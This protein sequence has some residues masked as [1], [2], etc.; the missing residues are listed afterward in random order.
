MSAVEV[1]TDQRVRSYGPGTWEGRNC[2]RSGRWG[3]S[4]AWSV[5]VTPFVVLELLIWKPGGGFLN[6]LV[7]NGNRLQ[8][9]FYFPIW[10]QLSPCF[11]RGKSVFFPHFLFFHVFFLS[12]FLIFHIFPIIFPLF[13]T[14]CT[15]SL[16]PPIWNRTLLALYYRYGRY[17]G[18][19]WE[20]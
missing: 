13:S 11:Y 8:V 18:E 16:G 10:F 5:G 20:R 6:H 2:G 12:P 3:R 19:G 1:G 14:T 17:G 9:H 15:R 7:V 4:W